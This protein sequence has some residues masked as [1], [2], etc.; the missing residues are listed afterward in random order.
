MLC[1]TIHRAVGRS[2]SLKSVPLRAFAAEG[3]KESK[4]TYTERMSL[5]G[6]PV[7]FLPLPYH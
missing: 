6:R 2:S 3:S 7:R 5:K 4:G 1:R